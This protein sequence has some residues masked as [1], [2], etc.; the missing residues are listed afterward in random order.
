MSDESTDDTQ[1]IGDVVDMHLE[2]ESEKR[3]I[4]LHDE[5]YHKVLFDADDS[6]AFLVD[7]DQAIELLDLCS[8]AVAALA[9]QYAPDKSPR[10]AIIQELQE[11][12][13]DE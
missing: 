5:D 11:V 9:P 6:V 13:G 1:E 4:V 7:N 10:E 3:W 12:G 2:Q 8:V